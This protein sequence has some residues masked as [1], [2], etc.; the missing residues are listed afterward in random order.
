MAGRKER[1]FNCPGC[2]V[3]VRTMWG[4]RKFCPECAEKRRQES[5]KKAEAK[6][7]E[8]RKAEAKKAADEKSD[9]K[10]YMHDSQEDIQKC[11]NCKKPKCGNCL[12][13]VYVKKAN[14]RADDG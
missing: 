11:L 1:V 6:R 12:G 5:A 10:L 4:T 2:G 9:N 7:Q 3:E 13:Y 14:R 8:R